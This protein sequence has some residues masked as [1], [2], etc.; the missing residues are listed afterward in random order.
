[1]RRLAVA[2]A[3]LFPTSAAAVPA[4][5]VVA[6]ATSGPA[7]LTVRFT[8]DPGVTDP[9]PAVV[10]YAWSFGDG[11]TATGQAVSHRFVK[12]GRYT[13]TVT[14]TDALGGTAA[15]TTQIQAQGLRLG[16][17]PPTVVFGNRVVARGVLVPAAP[18]A[19]VV[20]ERRGGSSWQPVASARTDSAGRFNA[21]LLAG[22]SGLWRARIGQLR[23]EA[24]TLTV[25]PQLQVEAGRGTAFLGASLLVR[26]RPRTTAPVQV[27][28]LRGGREVGRARGAPG[29]RFT[30]PTP[31]IGAF[32]ARIEIAGR[33]LTVP[34]RAGARTLSYGSTGPD[35]LALRARLVQLHVH[36]PWASPTFGSEMFDAIVAFQKAR[37]LSRTGAVDEETWRALSQ[38]V[39]PTPRYR[40]ARDHIE[41]SKSRQIL[42]VVHG[43]ETLAY[44]PVSSGAGGITPVG[45][46]HI[47][48][49]APSTST[50]LG[51]A[52]LYRTMTF[53]TH[54]AIHGFPSVPTYPASHGC[55]RIPIWAADW[56]YQQ[57]PVGEPVYVY[58]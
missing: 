12:A 46:Y 39:I 25:A 53:H 22:R 33:T 50:W 29:H 51:S 3:L 6:A 16:F 37:G 5:S 42:M 15:G 1:V 38:D 35:V 47:L 7:P 26:A 30:V 11:A 21:R 14:V 20:L 10:S 56:L 52:I 8:A 13:V 17:A 58:E 34:L 4:P 9:W 18:G 48:W 24:S 19:R 54:Y 36:V 55:V 31:G 44:L 23:S 49:K 32:T 27:T 40:I 28:V 57:S 43:G 41:V 45:N 2:V